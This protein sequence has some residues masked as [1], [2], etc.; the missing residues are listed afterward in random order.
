MKLKLMNLE[1]EKYFYNKNINLFK[2]IKKICV[3]CNYSNCICPTA[4]ETTK[5]IS[6]IKET[7]IKR[8]KFITEIH[9]DI[10]KDT[11]LTLKSE[12]GT[13]GQLDKNYLYLRG[14]VANRAKAILLRMGF[15]VLNTYCR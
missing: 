14:C 13:G 9:G 3:R 11:F 2:L 12:L 1:I 5:K 7:R 8:D 4:K 10:Q 6:V 15:E